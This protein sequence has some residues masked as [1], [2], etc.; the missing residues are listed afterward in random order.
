MAKRGNR[1][2]RSTREELESK[3]PGGAVTD[4]L[5]RHAHVVVEPIAED[6]MGF[7]TVARQKVR[8]KFQRMQDEGVLTQ[9]EAEAAEDLRNAADAYFRGTTVAYQM[10][11]DGSSRPGESMVAKMA[12]AQKVNN[13]LR[14]LT[15]E[16]RRVA[17]AFILEGI[18][19]HYGS[20]FL[21]IGSNILPNVKDE[22][23]RRAAGKALVIA[24]CRELAVFFKRQSGF[25][26]D[27]QQGITGVRF[28]KIRSSG[29]DSN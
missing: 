25:D 10:R 3:I 15:P 29:V 20:T 7:A 22:E 17:V 24:T 21:S 2:T 16:L 23:V 11:V 19:P 12:S 5:R 6:K 18:V 28:G 1:Q 4:E 26:F 8:S 27:I 9:A 14:Y 13:A